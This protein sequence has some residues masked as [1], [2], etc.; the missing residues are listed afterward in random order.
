MVASSDTDADPESSPRLRATHTLRLAPDPAP[1]VR[2]AADDAR[3]RP[4]VAVTDEALRRSLHEI[5]RAVLTPT[6]GGFRGHPLTEDAF[7]QLPVPALDA[8]ANALISACR[9]GRSPAA[10]AVENVVV[11]FWMLAQTLTDRTGTAIRRLFFRFIPTLINLAYR[12]FSDDPV[13][14]ADGAQALDRLQQ[15]LVE[16]STAC[17]TPS[18]SAR[19]LSAVDQ[20]AVFIEMGDYAIA[21]QVV[22]VQ[23]ERFLARNSLRR[24]LYHLMRAESEID[25]YIRGRLGRGEARIRLPEDVP[26]L[27]DYAPLR[28]FDE[29]RRGRSQR[30]MELQLPNIPRPED[31][32]V[33]LVGAGARTPFDRRLDNLGALELIVPDD[34]YELGL[35][36][37]PPRAS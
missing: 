18:E 34:S 14:R 6:E 32:V 23:L 9:R 24:A 35:V 1:G 25:R 37:D 8:R 19:V 27:G 31:V 4:V 30:L 2:A 5:L 36:Y 22:G 12:D 3:T 20:L 17:L 28:I 10:R 29:P 11:L 21:N 26:L 16:V 15:V 13:R 7:A 33:R